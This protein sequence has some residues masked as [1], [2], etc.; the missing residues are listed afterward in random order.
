MKRFIVG[1]LIGLL[2][3]SCSSAPRTV[4]CQTEEQALT[5]YAGIGVAY[6]SNVQVQL[7]DTLDRIVVP[8][9]ISSSTT[10]NGI[11]FT[12]NTYFE[13][14]V[15]FGEYMVKVIYQ[16]NEIEAYPITLTRSHSPLLTVFCS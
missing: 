7:I 9:N 5:G 11:A 13:N 15:D 2:L 6:T 16:S 10:A 12:T 3:V 14:A 4:S 8:S 1:V